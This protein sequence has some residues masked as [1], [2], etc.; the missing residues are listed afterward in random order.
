MASKIDRVLEQMRR[1]PDRSWSTS[2]LS[3]VLEVGVSKVHPY[4][5]TAV[6]DGRMHKRL[7]LG[8]REFRIKPFAKEAQPTATDDLRIPKFGSFGSWKP[9][10]MECARPGAGELRESAP[11][12]PTDDE[13]GKRTTS[14]ATASGRGIPDP[15]STP[16]PSE[17]A[18]QGQERHDTVQRHTTATSEGCGGAAN[19]GDA[20]VAS[21]GCARPEAAPVLAD[22]SIPLA[23]GEGG[24]P[25]DLADAAEDLEDENG[26]DCWL[27]G[28][29]GELLIVG[30]EPD[31]EGRITLTREQVE[32]V[33]RLV[34][35]ARPA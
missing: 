30:I 35:W 27:S 31:E 32:C 19:E 6:A 34:C 20:R 17:A 28:R 22:A 12:L 24:L 18:G 26:F 16:E 1:D 3:A 11:P 7:T 5:A 14:A 25:D 29:T 10:K 4:V 15:A 8:R 23:A 9:P 2:D 13:S 21:G 33:R